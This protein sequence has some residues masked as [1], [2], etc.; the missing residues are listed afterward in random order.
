MRPGAPNTLAQALRRF[1]VE[2]LPGV[3]GASV[4]TVRSYRDALVV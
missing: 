4:H 2:H 1:F 3:R